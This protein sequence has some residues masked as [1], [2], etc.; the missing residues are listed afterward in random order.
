MKATLSNY[1]QSPRKVRLV[2]NAISGKSADQALITLRFLV[3]RGAAPM[4]KLL[5][6]AIANAKAIERLEPTDLIV[7]SVMVNKGIVLKRMM[8]RAMG[9]GSRINKRTSHID[10]V[11]APKNPKK[12]EVEAEEKKAPKA[13]AKKVAK[14][15]VAKSAS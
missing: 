1:R 13:A 5:K 10:I 15:K 8:P 12:V 6:S 14:K 4:E 9:S 7:K 3:K 2:A 11:L